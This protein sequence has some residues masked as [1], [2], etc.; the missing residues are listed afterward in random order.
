[1]AAVMQL[2]ARV[3]ALDLGSA[4]EGRAG[5]RW[6]LGARARVRAAATVRGGAKG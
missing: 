1:M 3:D 4:S 6:G 2:V 5:E